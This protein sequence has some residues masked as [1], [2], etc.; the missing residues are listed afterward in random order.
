MRYLKKTFEYLFILEK[1]KRF[2]VISVLSLPVS[3]V[4]AWLF[5]SGKYT[6]WLANYNNRPNTF[7][8][9]W[10]F[11]SGGY[12]YW[13][14]L[15]L[16]FILIMIFVSM[17]VNIISRSLRIGIF[18]VK[19]L[20]TE[21]NDSFFPVLHGTL[22]Y[23]I[24]LSIYKT[25]L[26]LLLMFWQN[27][28]N[29][30]VYFALSL[31]TMI[32]MFVGAVACFSFTTLYIP[33][34]AFTGVRSRIAIYSSIRKSSSS[35][36]SLMIAVLIPILIKT[37]IGSLIALKH[38]ILLTFITDGVLNALLFS[39]MICFIMIAY[40]E[41]EQLKRQDYPREYFFKNKK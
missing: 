31:I 37:L 35:L 7:W 17:S 3:I 39:Y 2:A 15:L 8:D 23:I 27:I 10:T 26:S 33:I 28:S 13:I 5:P 34:M 20:L 30:H 24:L 22:T 21:L 9:A 4:F 41:I 38:D 36:V 1:G 18:K 16:A 25:I 29:S 11:N 32:V 19:S 6:T 40:Y 14:A 12:Q